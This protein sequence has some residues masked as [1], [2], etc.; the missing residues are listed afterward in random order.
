VAPTISTRFMQSD[1]SFGLAV[2]LRD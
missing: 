1:M 2:V